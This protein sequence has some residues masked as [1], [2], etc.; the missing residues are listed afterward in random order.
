MWWFVWFLFSKK[1]NHFQ[2]DLWFRVVHLISL[3]DERC[4]SPGGIS[5]LG[6]QGPA[7]PLHSCHPQGSP[8]GPWK[9]PN[10]CKWNE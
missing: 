5:V 10:A 2:K 1:K 8:A 3:L 4:C 7:C 9:V 6:G